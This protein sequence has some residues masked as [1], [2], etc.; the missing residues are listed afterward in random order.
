MNCVPSLRLWISLQLR[1]NSRVDDNQNIQRISPQIAFDISLNQAVLRMR[2]FDVEMTNGTPIPRRGNAQWPFA[3][4][5]LML[6]TTHYGS[7][8][9]HGCS[10]GRSI[11][12]NGVM[13]LRL[14]LMYLAEFEAHGSRTNLINFPSQRN[15]H[16]TSMIDT[17]ATAPQKIYR[18]GC[19]VSHIYQS[20]PGRPR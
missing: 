19:L 17:T 8:V 18:K 14:R 9:Y 4:E 12:S 6:L 1:F 2:Y 16:Y 13:R 11:S 5:P 20:E 7:S 15:L 3:R 10:T